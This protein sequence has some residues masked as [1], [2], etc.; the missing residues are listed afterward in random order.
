MNEARFRIDGSWTLIS[1]CS[2]T[3][4]HWETSVKAPPRLESVRLRD[5]V[6]VAETAAGP[7]FGIFRRLG[8]IWGFCQASL[9]RSGPP[10]DVLESPRAVGVGGR[11]DL[12]E[13]WESIY[14]KRSPSE[15]SWFEPIPET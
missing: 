1:Y 8:P 9:R 4:S 13:H 7:F 10:C 3:W 15:V 12:H 6:G 2:S 11:M 5:R 14:R